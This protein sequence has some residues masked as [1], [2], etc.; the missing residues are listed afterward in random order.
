MA[1]GR[2][3]LLAAG[4]AVAVSAL[5][6][7]LLAP[8]SPPAPSPTT[9]PPVSS[10][11]ATSSPPPR[12]ATPPAPA[13]AAPPSAA[14]PAPVAVK[15]SAP[16]AAAP[17]RA[18]TGQD[19]GGTVSETRGAARLYV[20]RIPDDAVQVDVS[21]RST[22]GDVEL[23][24][25]CAETPPERDDDWSW[26]AHADGEHAKLSLTRHAESDLRSGPFLVEVRPIS[27]AAHHGDRRNL[28]FT[29]RVDAT[30]LAAPRA[31]V[32]GSAVDAATSPAE[33]HRCDFVVEVPKDA[34][35][36]RIDLVE[37]ERD[38]DVIASQKGTPL[39]AD[40]AEWTA[41]SALARESV[42]IGADSDPKLT[43]GGKL[44]FA[45]VDPSLYD[46]PVSFRVIVTLGTD[47]PAEALAIPVLPQPSDPRDRAVAAVV[48]II[49][50][51]GSGSGTIV[52]EDGLVLTARHVVGDRTGDDGDISIAMD[53]DTLAMTRDLFRAKVV[54]T[55]EA[56]DVALLRITSGLRGQPLPTDY[57]FPACPVAFDALPRLGDELVTLGFPEPAGTGTRAPVMFSKGVVSGFERERAGL[58]I[59]TD[60]FVAS[61]SSGGA[62]LDS[63]YRLVGVPV[64]TMSDSD[65]TALLGF[66]V[67]VTELPKEWRAMMVR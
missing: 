18:E 28:P 19:V 31:I 1:E 5:V 22:D 61:G 45:V 23:R 63:R 26:T 7:V 17:V 37:A 4:L 62:A 38:F 2:T 32:P 10:P 65:H 53:L 21:L 49:V 13:P 16:T 30:R 43:G 15:P 3:I 46:A 64:F 48:E 66:L 44:W 25:V 51:D 35:A 67:P 41:E 36:L 52:T 56:L 8:S 42:V 50:E 33:G 11:P 34:K 14:E 58:R 57:R 59:K 40:A 27:A 6:T 55:D 47:P 29:L 39:D 9:A 20:F 24:A 12:V 60:A 54:K